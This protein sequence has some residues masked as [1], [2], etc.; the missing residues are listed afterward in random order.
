[1]NEIE[2]LRALRDEVPAE[3]DLRAE[4]PRL[5]ARI[6][7]GSSAPHRRPGRRLAPRLRWGFALAGAC[8]LTATVVTVTQSGGTP[9]TTFGETGAPSVAQPPSAAV[10][11]ENAA[12]VAARTKVADIRPDQWLYH[13]ESQHFDQDLPVFEHWSRMDGL[14]EAVR[15]NGKLKIGDG[16][17]GPTNA[18]RTQREVESLPT[19]P[20]ALLEHFRNLDKERTPLSICQP[21]CPAGTERD[22]KAFGA[23]GWYMK[24]GP[25]IPPQTT[26]AMYRALAKIPNVTIEEKTL[27]GD[28]REGIGVVLTVTPDLKGY[29]ILDPEDYRYLG[30]KVVDGDRTSAMSVLDTGIVDEA[31]QTP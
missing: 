21:N 9:G 30:T 8:A 14:K 7:E 17:K 23:I 11:L 10:V 29:Y 31:G 22:I 15:T 13:K 28:G 24:Y 5:L 6:R 16:E 3:P 27:D 4:E 1:M 12:L 2:L 18:T 20:D 25:M 26:A 19:D